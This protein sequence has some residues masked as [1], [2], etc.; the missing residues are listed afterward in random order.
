MRRGLVLAMLVLATPAWSTPKQTG[1]VFADFGAF[2]PVA[3]DLAIPK[4][5]KLHH[6]YDVTVAAAGTRR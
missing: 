6:I 4:G 3:S 5:L 1:P 2:V